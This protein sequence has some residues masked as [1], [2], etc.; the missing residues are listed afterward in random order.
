[1]GSDKN[2]KGQH[3]DRKGK[4][5]VFSQVRARKN[6][7]Q[8][9]CNRLYRQERAAG[10]VGETADAMYQQLCG[11]APKEW[12]LKLEYFD[13][14]IEELE[15][16]IALQ[17][18]PPALPDAPA[19]LD[20]PAVPDAVQ[21]PAVGADAPPGPSSSHACALAPAPVVVAA[22]AVCAPAA[23][24]DASA[25]PD[26]AAATD[27]PAAAEDDPVFMA[28]D[29]EDPEPEPWHIPYVEAGKRKLES[30][31]KQEERLLAGAN[32]KTAVNR[33][34]R[35]CYAAPPSWPEKVTYFDQLIKNLEIQIAKWLVTPP[36]APA[37]LFAPA[38]AH[39]PAATALDDD[40]DVIVG[41]LDAA[42]AVA[43]APAATTAAAVA[44]D[45]LEMFSDDDDII[46][47]ALDALPVAAQDQEMFSDDDA[48]L[49]GAL[50]AVDEGKEGDPSNIVDTEKEAHAIFARAVNDNI[51]RITLDNMGALFSSI[52]LP[53]RSYP[54]EDNA[55]PPVSDNE[56]RLFDD[57]VITGSIHSGTAETEPV[58]LVGRVRHRVSEPT[59]GS[60]IIHMDVS[61]SNFEVLPEHDV[62]LPNQENE[63]G[64]NQGGLNQ[65]ELADQPPPPLP[66]Y[67]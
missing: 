31:C 3:T 66:K 20:A 51:D 56:V 58:G 14:V 24:P 60:P 59:D 2:K 61:D 5:T 30:L 38:V 49:V 36:S 34:E 6:K 29:I 25:V 43:H 21:P 45:N 18:A 41:A 63:E 55:A 26:A 48:V 65:G 1:M 52:D 12:H 28:W 4:V 57:P 53:E 50:N 17:N 44:A 9:L 64:L 22:T 8:V 39:A 62:Q 35:L 27:D 67:P 10:N 15:N 23:V 32:V 47:G 7:V 42:P 13:P 11:A 37:Q 16:L 33:Y 46:A 54:Y 19:V 40:D